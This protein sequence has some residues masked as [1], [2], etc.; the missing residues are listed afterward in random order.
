MSS[1]VLRERPEPSNLRK[2]PHG[3][4]TPVADEF[5]DFAGAF[6]KVG[7]NMLTQFRRSFGP[8][9]KL[10]KLVPAYSELDLERATATAGTHGIGIMEGESRAL[11]TIQVVDFRAFQIQRAL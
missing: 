6:R 4:I 11:Q 9:P 5:P 10:R 8:M 2:Q 3:A 7:R 1:R